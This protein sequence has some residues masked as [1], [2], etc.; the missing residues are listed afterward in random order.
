VPGVAVEEPARP[1][2]VT[3]EGT[4]P[5][6][7]TAVAEERPEPVPPS[8]V[9]LPEGLDAASSR[10]RKRGPG[11]YR[12]E[13]QFEQRTDADPLGR[14]ADATVWVNTAHPA[15]Q[16]AVAS[17]AEG[18][19]LAVVVGMV[20]APLAVA[21]VEAHQFLERFLARWGDATNTHQRGR[22]RRQRRR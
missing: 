10:K 3:G 14:L 13:I 9:P 4:T 5:E 6:R 21:P 20:L 8:A 18:Y 7:V 19:H 17:R 22:S 12:L 16:R 2:E 15:Y 1:P 11:H